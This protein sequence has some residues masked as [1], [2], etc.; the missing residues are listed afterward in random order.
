MSPPSAATTDVC[1]AELMC[2]MLSRSSAAASSSMYMPNFVL[3]Q[4]YSNSLESTDIKTLYEYF[5]WPSKQQ[6]VQSRVSICDFKAAQVVC[7]FWSIPRSVYTCTISIRERWCSEKSYFY[8]ML[9]SITA[10]QYEPRE[11]HMV[12]QET[13]CVIFSPKRNY[14]YLILKMRKAILQYSTKDT[15]EKNIHICGSFQFFYEWIK[16]ILKDKGVK[17]GSDFS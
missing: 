2:F 13:M 12:N 14:P 7:W 17:T 4:S 9:L 11:N 5:G 1:D 16:D 15:R 8:L 3:D 6:I 10:E